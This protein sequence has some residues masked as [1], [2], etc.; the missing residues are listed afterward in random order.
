MKKYIFIGVVICLIYNNGCF[1]PIALFTGYIYNN[2][3]SSLNIEFTDKSLEKPYVNVPPK[4]LKNIPI[5]FPFIINRKYYNTKTFLQFIDHIKVKKMNTKIVFYLQY[6]GDGNIYIVNK[7]GR[8]LELPDN[9]IEFPVINIPV[10][11]S[12]FPLKPEN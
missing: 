3:N 1:P 8:Y 6:E 12:G 7:D 2:T 10:Q 11:P 4:S 9:K 5:K